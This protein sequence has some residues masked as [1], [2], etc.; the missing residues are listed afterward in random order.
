MVP[1]LLFA[2]GLNPRWQREAHAIIEVQG[3]LTSFA[4]G[5]LFTF[6]P[7]RLKAPMPAPWE[8]GPVLGG[9]VASPRSPGRGTSGGRT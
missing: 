2:L 9:V 5:F 1:W 8:V 7:R 3:F 4:A 6:V